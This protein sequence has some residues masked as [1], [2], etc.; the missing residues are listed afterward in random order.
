M[1]STSGMLTMPFE[2]AGVVVGDVAGELG[3][4]AE[5]RLGRDDV[6]HAG[7]GVAAVERALRPAQH[8]DPLQVVEFL[9][10]EAVT[11]ERR[12]VERHRD[13]RVGRSFGISLSWRSIEDETW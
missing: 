10:E 2:A 8:F 12:V 1:S 9:L 4:V 5:L 3:L 6:D 13:G 7:R 11:D